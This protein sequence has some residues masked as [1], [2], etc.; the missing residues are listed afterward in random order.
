MGSDNNLYNCFNILIVNNF[1]VIKV[2]LFLDIIKKSVMTLT[3]II[4]NF[5]SPV[6]Q[7]IKQRD[8]FLFDR[9]SSELYLLLR[10]CG[11]NK[12]FVL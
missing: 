6:R 4:T 1:M 5:K 3:H 9:L 11:K 2:I 8:I 10:G 7:N 12:F